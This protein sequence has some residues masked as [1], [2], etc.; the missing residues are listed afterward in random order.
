[1]EMPF[2]LLIL[3]TDGYE[4]ISYALNRNSEQNYQKIVKPNLSNEDLCENAEQQYG[5]H[6]SDNYSELAGYIAWY[7]PIQKGVE[8]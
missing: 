2:I 1:M 6:L 4:D 5:L 8:L 3:S 7:P